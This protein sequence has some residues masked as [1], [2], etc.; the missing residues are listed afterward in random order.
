MP[1]DTR[2]LGTDCA[3]NFELQYPTVQKAQFSS[4]KSLH[5]TCISALS[6]QLC[7]SS[8][9]RQCVRYDESHSSALAAPPPPRLGALDVYAVSLSTSRRPR[10]LDPERAAVRCPPRR[11][12]TAS[13]AA[14]EARRR[15]P[16]GR[17]GV[18]RR[19]SEPAGLHRR[20]QA[21]L[22]RGRASGAGRRGVDGLHKRVSFSRGTPKVPWGGLRAVD[23]ETAIG[24]R[25]TSAR[26]SKIL[27]SRPGS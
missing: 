17:H 4:R 14:R 24:R 3:R 20:H 19:R 8:P 21:E 1:P 25:S 13:A 26:R 10:L 5:S 11:P 16:P 15:R 23:A 18:G 7:D 9:Y 12:R 22:R 6:L 27:A 2:H